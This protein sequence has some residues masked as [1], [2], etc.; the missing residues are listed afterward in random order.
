[1][2]NLETKKLKFE[3][4]FALL[5]ESLMSFSEDFKAGTSG[6][7][8]EEVSWAIWKGKRYTEVV[9][10]IHVAFS[11]TTY[12]LAISILSKDK[13]AI[14]FLAAT[15]K[16][17][18]IGTKVVNAIL[19]AA[20]DSGVIVEVFASPFDSKY[21]DVPV[22]KLT[23]AMK[24]EQERSI[25]RLIDWYRSFGFESLDKKFPFKLQYKVA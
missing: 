20:E 15:E 1:M 3:T 22:N 25:I 11:A 8:R 13:V 19:D 9:N 7:M 12:N 2:E 23:R 18:G 10:T 5:E 16:G 4:F 24:E 17:K 21:A 14:Q 6:V